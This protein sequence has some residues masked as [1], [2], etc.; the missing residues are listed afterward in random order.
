MRPGERIIRAQQQSDLW[1]AARLGRVT[2]SRLA[3]VMAPPT[4]RASVRKGVSMPAGSEAAA[5]EDYRRELVVERLYRRQV[6]HFPTKAMLE[7][8][9][10]EPFACM[11]Y[12]AA[13]MTDDKVELVGFALHPEWDWFG[14]SADGLCGDDGGVELKNPTDMVHDSYAT[15]IQVLVDEYKWQCLGCLTCFPERQ[16]WDLCS[17]DPYAPG[18]IKLVKFRFHRSDWQTTIDAIEEK[19]LEM[20]ESVEA[21]IQ[22]R[23]FDPTV[24]KIMPPENDPSAQKTQRKPK[25]AAAA[26]DPLAE[27]SG[28]TDEDLPAW[29]RDM[30]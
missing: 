21:E 16:W 4:T 29:Y 20:H 2:G 3:D 19:S 12:E 13:Y 8:I 24:F 17:F 22:R 7:G 28:I 11:F 14:A 30:K 6:S 15:N 9:E 23:G 5:M 27:G 18:S 25:Q 10:R 1:L 26:V